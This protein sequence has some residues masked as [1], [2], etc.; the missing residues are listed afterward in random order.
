VFKVED[1]VNEL[2]D[3][4]DDLALEIV[5]R[6]YEGKLHHI[7]PEGPQYNYTDGTLILELHSEI[8]EANE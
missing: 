7:V 5:V 6:D 2:E 4:S 1:L 8:E 3:A